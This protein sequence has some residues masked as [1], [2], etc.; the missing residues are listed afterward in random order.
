MDLNRVALFV[1]VVTT[2]GF[3]AAA[4][5]LGLPKSSVS[6]SVAMLEDE[7]GVRLL[8]RTTRK[9]AL[10]DA[11]QNYFDAVSPSVLALQ[12]ADE[13]VRDQ[14]SEPRGVVRIT[15]PPD[16]AGLADVLARFTQVHP[17]VR[18]EVSLT[19]RYVDLVAE[20]FDLAVRAGKLSDSSLIARRLGPAEMAV[21]AAPAYLDRRGRPTTVQDLKDH[22]WVLYRATDGRASLTLTD[23]DGV[24]HIV[25]VKGN[26]VIDDLSMCRRAV[27]AGAGLALLPMHTLGDALLA[28]ELE[29][30]LRGYRNGS[31][32]IYVLTPTTRNLATRVALVRDFLTEHLSTHLAAVT[33]KCSPAPTT[34]ATTR[35]P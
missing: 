9:I 5:E 16:V 10:T 25:E 23:D 20:G 18:I 8:H 1:K 15:A 31:A 3:T 2:G 30:V 14:G 34:T 22:D 29:H 24:D 7:L 6:R 21:M 35:Q 12:A 26:V 32:G 28:G 19:S 4:D 33:P 11:G 27:E 17:L 13:A